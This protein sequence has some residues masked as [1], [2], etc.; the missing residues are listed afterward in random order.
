MTIPRS[1]FLV[2]TLT[3]GVLAVHPFFSQ[4][5]ATPGAYRVFIGTYTGEKSRGIY[6]AQFDPATGQLSTPELA[7]ECKN[8]AF[9]AVHPNGRVLYAANEVGDFGGKHQGSISAYS[10]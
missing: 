4:A 1:T 7:T 6:G 10:I 3:A 2:R 8:P 9:L 5:A